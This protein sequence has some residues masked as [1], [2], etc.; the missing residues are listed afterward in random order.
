MA[1]LSTGLC[2]WDGYEILAAQLTADFEPS[3]V[4]CDNPAVHTAI[5]RRAGDGLTVE[6]SADVCETH[7]LVLSTAPGWVTS[8][9]IRRA[10]DVWA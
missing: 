5:V 1:A 6:V 7:D 3:G 2:R 10:K 9:R 8:R 4:T